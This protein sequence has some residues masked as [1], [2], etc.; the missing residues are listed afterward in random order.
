MSQYYVENN[1]SLLSLNLS[2]HDGLCEGYYDGILKYIGGA[3]A[4]YNESIVD[5]DAAVRFVQQLGYHRI[6]LQGHSLGCDKAIDYLLTYPNE[7]LELILLSPVDS[8]AAQTKWLNKHK[9]ES[10]YEQLN[11]LKSV[12]LS[13]AGLQWLPID[14]YGA[15]GADENW[16][17]KIPITRDCL[18]SILEGTA[19]KYLNLESE[20]SFFIKNRS[21][22]FLGM[23]DGLQISTQFKFKAFLQR[24]FGELY[25]VDDLYSD[26]DIKGVEMALTSKIIKWIKN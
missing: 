26:H 6:I 20:D 19:F 16:V 22:A 13:D 11:R 2:A 12:Y 15:E 8:F 17:Y 5:I 1:I 10:V 7:S 14:E 3:V 18:I 23:N 9:K 24:H 4:N 21:F 25:V